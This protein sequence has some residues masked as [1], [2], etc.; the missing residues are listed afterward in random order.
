[1]SSFYQYD[2]EELRKAMGVK[3]PSEVPSPP[4]FVLAAERRRVARQYLSR[5]FE[6]IN[7]YL[8]LPIPAQ[9]HAC[10]A[11]KRIVTGSNRSS[12]TFSVAAETARAWLGCDPFKKYRPTEGNSIFVGLDLD[13]CAMFWRKATM[14]GEFSIIPDEHTGMWRA[15]RPDPKDPRHIDPYDLAYQERW[16]NA[17][18]LIPSK[19]Y[20]VAWEDKNKGIPRYVRFRRTG[21]RCLFRSS[22]GKAA[23]GDAFDLAIFDE[24]QSSLDWY[25]EVIRGLVG[26]HVPNGWHPKLVWSATSQ[27]ANIELATLRDRAAAGDGGVKQFDLL[28][29]DNPYF[30]DASKA[31][32]EASLPEDERQTRIHG[33]PAMQLRRIYPT[34]NPQVDVEDGGHGCEPFEIDPAKFSR[35]VIIDPGI[36]HCVALFVAIDENEKH[37]TVYDAVD[38]K[39][40]TASVCASEIKLR[41][42]GRPFE[43]FVIDARMAGQS[44]MTQYKTTVAQEYWTALMKAECRPRQRGP[45][46]GFYPSNND[47][48]ARCE[49][50]RSWMELRG[51]DS[52]FAGTPVLRVMRGIV[53][54]LDR[55]IRMASSD[56][57]ND[58]KRLKLE[59]VACDH[60]DALEYAAAFRP[61]YHT[62]ADLIP[63]DD[64]PAL[65][66]YREWQ[67]AH[68]RREARETAGVSM[69]H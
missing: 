41:E 11:E 61:R 13:H 43:A 68:E 38:L 52:P 9:F 35:Y 21:W 66:Q 3:T 4:P 62:P 37:A 12:K 48:E 1:V 69:Y 32:F 50:L 22:E 47:I 24:E 39:G 18:P 55:Q 27:V 28:M 2:P 34:Y 60:L 45:F 49:C 14:E 17:P 25:Y 44:P 10:N 42:K 15:V 63:A 26:R 6:G 23:Q 46:Y 30:T 40:A 59:K 16:R 8:P 19:A 36:K 57:K 5:K 7:L 29:W 64:S 33:V 67:S 20:D 58:K 31:E 56:P 53:P 51:T 65:K 54:T